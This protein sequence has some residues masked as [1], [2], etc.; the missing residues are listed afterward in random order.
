MEKIN[1]IIANNLIYL[2]KKSNL[3]QTQFGNRFNYSDKTVSK[4]EQGL[5]VPSVETLIEISEF[6]GVS[7]D[8]L[9]HEHFTQKD[10]DSG[11]KQNVEK[12][13]KII[14]IA[15][16]A[17]FVLLI[18]VTIYVASIYNLG[19][20]DPNKNRWWTVFLWM[21]PVMC[22]FS[23][24]FTWRFFKN[25]NAVYILFSITIWTLLLSS[26]ITFLYKGIYWYL[27]FIGI[28]LQAG[29]ILLMKLNS[30]SKK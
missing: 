30:N 29:I 1:I 20:S 2:R 17:V 7:L 6:Y 28:P 15:L 26:F 24:Y 3:T 18:A 11:V 22:G 27:F 21:L 19:T 4:W 23:S 25:L 8:Y 14:L 16:V 9:T 12:S 10:F 5:V 13:N